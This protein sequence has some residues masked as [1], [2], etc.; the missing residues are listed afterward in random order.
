MYTICAEGSEVAEYQ[1]TMRVV[2]K[3]P[4]DVCSDAGGAVGW[5]QRW[6]YVH[7]STQG[8]SA[9]FL[10]VEKANIRIGKL[11]SGRTSHQPRVLYNLLL[12]A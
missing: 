7:G 5:H 12:F 11:L 6:K 4:G 8:R 1:P 9:H 3:D 10:P 2:M